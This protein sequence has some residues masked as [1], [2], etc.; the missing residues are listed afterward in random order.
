MKNLPKNEYDTFQEILSQYKTANEA[1]AEE[2]LAMERKFRQSTLALT[3]KRSEFLKKIPQFWITCMTKHTDLKPYLDDDDVVEFLK[4][5]MV[6][7]RVVFAVD[8]ATFGSDNVKKYGRDGLVIMVEFKDNPAFSNK[9]FTKAIGKKI[10]DGTDVAFCEGTQI[11][12][13]DEKLKAKFMGPV[14]D[15]QCSEDSDDCDID[16][17][18]VEAFSKQLG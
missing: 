6:D 16:D 7:L 1:Y 11:M 17:A 10:I 5:Y 18:E 13:T 3:S 14:D 8:E 2:I 15:D 12:W 4:T 9:Y